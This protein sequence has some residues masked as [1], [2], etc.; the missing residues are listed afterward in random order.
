MR[1]FSVLIIISMLFTSVACGIP[2]LKKSVD[3]VKPSVEV[4]IEPTQEVFSEPTETSY[5]PPTA[6][7][8]SNETP[9]PTE[10]SEATQPPAPTAPQQVEASCPAYGIEEFD[11]PTDCWPNTLDD[12][13]TTTS[14]SDRNKV[15]VQITDSRLEFSS[16]LKEDVFLYSF[17]KENEYD[18]VIIRA[19][20]TKIEPSA[21]QNGFT[22]LCHANQF[23][24]YEARLE[25]SGVF[26]IFQYDQLKRQS[27]ANPFVRLGNGGVSSFK[28]GAGREN[29]I[30]WQCG[31]DYLR[32]IVNDKQIWEKVGFSS[33]NN[34]G[35]VGVGLASYSGASPRRIGFEYVEI[36]EP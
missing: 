36:L 3:Q 18:E 27:G 1:K 2:Q 19:S 33:L 23:G 20:V 12:V 30:E 7:P 9:V 26:E 34:G 24:W 15:N 29:L 22:L 32:L 16:Q 11:S 4:I 31:Y 17:Y 14:I 35:R 6:R 5:S 10:T 25:S 13:T 28:T 21:N 8:T